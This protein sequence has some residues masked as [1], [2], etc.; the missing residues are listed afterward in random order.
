MNTYGVR[1]GDFEA[2]KNRLLLLNGLIFLSV[3]VGLVFIFPF[4]DKIGIIAMT[5][6]IVLVL[7]IAFFAIKRTIRRLRE[8]WSTYSLTIDDD[9]ILRTQLHHADIKIHKDEIKT[10]KKS[11]TGDLVVKSSD[12]RKFLI[13]P[14]SLNGLE[15][16]ERLL[17]QW[18]PIKPTSRRTLIL[19]LSSAIV[20]FFGL[21]LLLRYVFSRF[22]YSNRHPDMLSIKIIILVLMVISFIPLWVLRS[23]PQIDKRAKPKPWLFVLLI[24]YLILVVLSI[25]ISI[26]IRIP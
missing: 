26:F 21:L 1:P 25:A 18:K 4:R 23:M 5:T 19:S 16:V 24:G 2:F 7:I 3:S 13:I 9:F 6:A 20:I 17:S 15:E 14:R 12:W 11:F 10:I 8:V 22:I